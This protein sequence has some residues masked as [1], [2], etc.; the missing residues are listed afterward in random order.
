MKILDKLYGWYGR[1]TVRFF[2]GLVTALVIYGLFFGG[3]AKQPD[4][5]SGIVSENL[6]AVT[7]TTVSE[8]ENPENI[9]FIR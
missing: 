6:P 4:M 8:L 3:G 2:I 5:V 1:K 7:L 9:S